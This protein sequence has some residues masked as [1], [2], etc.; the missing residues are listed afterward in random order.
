M[1]VNSLISKLNNFDDI[2]FDLDNTLFDQK[3]YDIGAFEDIE[4][5]LTALSQLTLSGFAKFLYNHKQKM[6]SNY[7]FLFNDALTKYKL[8]QHYLTVMLTEYYHHN[9]HYIKEK[10]SLIPSLLT[11]FS[12][13]KTFIVT[14]GP[15]IVQQTKIDKLRLKN[16]TSEIIICEPK[17]PKTLK[18]NRYAFD[19]LKNKHSLTSTVMVGDTIETDGLFAK[20]ADIP[21]IHFSYIDYCHENT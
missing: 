9:G 16:Y 17:L 2:I 19:L 1:L 15:T 18:P 13:K 11:I 21:F 3:D 7:P 4:I 10:K 5:K 8:S 12:T 14:N 6:G 20:N